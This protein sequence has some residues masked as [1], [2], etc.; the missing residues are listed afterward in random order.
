MK[1]NMNKLFLCLMAMMGVLTASAQD[2]VLPLIQN[3]KAY[4]GVS[5]NGEWNYIVD[6]QEEG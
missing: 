5:L 4:E 1:K 3:V 6:V 2:A